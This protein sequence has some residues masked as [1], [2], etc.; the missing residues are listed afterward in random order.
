MSNQAK[1]MEADKALGIIRQKRN[2][3]LR[4]FQAEC[5]HLALA[6]CRSLGDHMGGARV[7]VNCGTREN[8]PIAISGNEYDWNTYGNYKIL[9]GQVVTDC[10]SNELYAISLSKI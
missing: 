4:A 5:P 2:E 8:Q 7:C 10:K 1:F 9:T 6:E 3:L